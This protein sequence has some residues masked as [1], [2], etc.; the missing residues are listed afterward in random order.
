MF[1]DFL[2]VIDNKNFLKQKGYVA[3][4]EILLGFLVDLRKEGKWL[5]VVE[6]IGIFLSFFGFFEKLELDFGLLD[7]IMFQ[8]FDIW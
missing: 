1:L 5:C 3:G 7:Q 4:G 2:V 8:G 6:Q